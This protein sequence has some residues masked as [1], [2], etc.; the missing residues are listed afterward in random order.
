MEKK[1]KKTFKPKKLVSLSLS[2]SSSKLTHA[3]W[4]YKTTTRGTSLVMLSCRRRRWS[5]VAPR[6]RGRRRHG[7]TVF[8]FDLSPSFDPSSSLFLV[9]QQERSSLVLCC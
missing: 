6:R 7:F 3:V 9:L 5:A 8:F 4:R 2:F 1:K